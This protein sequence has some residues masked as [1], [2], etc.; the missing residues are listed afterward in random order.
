MEIQI[1]IVFAVL[2]LILNFL[3][4]A[5]MLSLIPSISPSPNAKKLFL[6]LSV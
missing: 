1:N 3:S 2:K 4:A 6:G 5:S